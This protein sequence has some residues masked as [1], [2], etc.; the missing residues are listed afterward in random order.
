[1]TEYL[2][3]T[4]QPSFF[5]FFIYSSTLFPF[6]SQ[7]LLVAYNN[8][9]KF[10]FIK[11]LFQI[12]FLIV[13]TCHRVECFLNKKILN[14]MINFFYLQSMY[15]LFHSLILVLFNLLFLTTFYC[16]R[17]NI[18]FLLNILCH[19]FSNL[20]MFPCNHLHLLILIIYRWSIFFSIV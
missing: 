5:K 20:H 6:Y 8:Q 1:M 10:L 17:L 14:I 13:T 18:F 12:L 15:L 11:F 16:V 4:Y 3:C 2:F 7:F 9:H 19:Y